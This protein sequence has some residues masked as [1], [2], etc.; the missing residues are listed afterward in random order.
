MPKFIIH[1]S[2]TKSYWLTIQAPD[3]DTARRFYDGS[4]GTE[5]HESQDEGCWV[6]NEIEEVHQEKGGR[7][8][9]IDFVVDKDGEVV[10]EK[11]P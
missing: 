3:F 7:W 9:P 4:D 1:C 2:T 8:D 11:T 5:F 10:K 6:L